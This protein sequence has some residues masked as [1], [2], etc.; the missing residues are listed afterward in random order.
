[1][2]RKAPYQAIQEAFAA[3]W[4]VVLDPDHQLGETPFYIVTHPSDPGEGRS[5]RPRIFESVYLENSAGWRAVTRYLRKPG[6]LHIPADQWLREQFEFEF[7][8]ECGGDAEH[9]TAVPFMGNWFARCD[10]PPDE[11]TGELHPIIKAFRK[12]GDADFEEIP[13]IF[14]AERGCRATATGRDDGYRHITA[15]FPTEPATPD[16]Y[17]ATCYA[18]IGQ[19]S[20]CRRAWYRTTEPATPEQY[21]DLLAELRRI[22]ETG[23]DAV[24]LKIVKRWTQRHDEARRAAL[25]ATERPA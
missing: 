14:R 17:T 9:H 25:R 12:A 24:R 10:Y 20:G 2:R 15:V 7:C 1:M 3:G 13:V 22:Y 6:N 19:H 4:N 8:A 23:P 11:S 18:H 5:G 16:P 21:A